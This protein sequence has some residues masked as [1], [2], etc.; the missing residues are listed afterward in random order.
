MKRFQCTYCKQWFE[1]NAP[2]AFACKKPECQKEHRRS[3]NQFSN[4]R[5]P[6]SPPVVTRKCEVCGSKFETHPV[7]NFKYCSETCRKMARTK[8]YKAAKMFP[9]AEPV[10]REYFRA[11]PERNWR[12]PGYDYCRECVRLADQYSHD[13]AQVNEWTPVGD[14][15]RKRVLQDLRNIH[16]HQEQCHGIRRNVEADAKQLEL[17]GL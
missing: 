1:S 14:P 4:P 2:V 11:M 6:K 17:R 15:K 7:G 5:R 10:R 16:V 8:L 13:A 12:G 3:Y 9:S